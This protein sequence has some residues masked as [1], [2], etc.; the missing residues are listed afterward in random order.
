M[1]F[2]TQNKAKLFKKL[3]ITL[4]FEEN[5]NFFAENCQNSQKIAII[6]STPGLA[7]GIFS[8]QKSP[9]GV[10]FGGSFNGRFCYI[11]WQIGLFYGH[12]VY[13]KVIW[14]IFPVLVYFAKKNP[15]TILERRHWSQSYDF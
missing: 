8:N 13:F 12:F 11:L 5:A 15:A 4:V 10:N 2:L 1:G 9:F 7:G 6:T 14:Y 3:I